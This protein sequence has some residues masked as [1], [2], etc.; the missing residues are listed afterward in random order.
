MAQLRQDY[1]QFEQRATE[2]IAI[3]PEDP[4]TFASWWKE[5]NMPFVGLA[6]PDHAVADLFGQEVNL[7]KLG[8]MP[9]QFVVDIHGQLRYQHHSNAMWDLPANDDIL[10]LLDTINQEAK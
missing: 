2:V 9:A 6:D 1:P 4:P 8:R 3:G 10:N 7:V 5:H